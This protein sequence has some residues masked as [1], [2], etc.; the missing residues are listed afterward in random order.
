M[1]RVVNKTAVQRSSKVS[2]PISFLDPWV[3]GF[4]FKGIVA[5]L[6]C[7]TCASQSI[8]AKED[9]QIL[10]IVN[11]HKIYAKE[12]E[13]WL[14]YHPQVAGADLLT[15]RQTGFNDILTRTLILQDV[16]TLKLL[17]RPENQ[18]QYQQGKENVLIELWFENYLKKHPISEGDIQAEYDR[19]LA[20]TQPGGINAKQLKISQMVL[21][22]EREAKEVVRQ[23]RAGADFAQL[24]RIQSTDLNSAKNGG[25]LDWLL[26]TQL[27]SPLG[28]MVSDLN[29][30][31]TT[32]PIK[33]PNGWLI[34]RLDNVRD[35]QMPAF[36]EIKN[37]IAQSLLQKRRQKALDSL[38]KAAKIE[39]DTHVK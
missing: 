30:G 27:I 10:G 3:L 34:I 13:D 35:F 20:T 24:L 9:Q 4:Q 15:M 28:E 21:K 25:E 1:L 19:Q 32:S 22:T 36:D 5:L 33:T 2:K 17:D 18:Y 16:E 14:K 8:L 11:G 39:Q 37:N 38:V 26:P 29:I 23:L 6:L 31:K 12:L 7:M